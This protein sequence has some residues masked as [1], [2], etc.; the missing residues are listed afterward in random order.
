MKNLIGFTLSAMVLGITT[1]LILAKPF[2]VGFEYGVK[3][4]WLKFP[5]MFNG[6]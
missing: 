5:K 3:K 6:K 4:R 1:S 2:L